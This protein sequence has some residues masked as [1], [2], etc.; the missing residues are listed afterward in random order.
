MKEIKF[1]GKSLDDNK[2]YHGIFVQQGN[3]FN[4]PSSVIIEGYIEDDYGNSFDFDNWHEVDENTVGQ[5]IGKK[6]KNG[7]DI[8]EGDILS[9]KFNNCKTEY[10]GLVEYNN[11]SLKYTLGYINYFDVCF[12]DSFDLGQTLN[13]NCNAEVIGNV[14]D[15]KELLGI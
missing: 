7:V 12:A 9:L 1:R 15:N 2:W 5:F 8:Y 4:E 3:Y 14:Y 13:E 6:D 10:I 11:E